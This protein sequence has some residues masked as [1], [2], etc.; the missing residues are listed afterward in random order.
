MGSEGL[1]YLDC[2]QGK[3]VIRRHSEVRRI[4]VPQNNTLRDMIGHFVDCIN[5]RSRSEPFPNLIDGT[6]GARVVTLVDAA[7][8]S[9][10]QGRR[11]TLRLPKVARQELASSSES[12]LELVE[13]Q[14]SNEPSEN[15]SID[16]PSASGG[17]FSIS[18][19]MEAALEGK[20]RGSRYRMEILLRLGVADAGPKDLATS[21]GLDISNLGK[22]LRDL[23][24][25]GLVMLKTPSDMRK[26]KIYGL[27]RKGYELFGRISGVPAVRNASDDFGAVES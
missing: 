23:A 3:A 14:G 22:Y 19:A 16:R 20:L 11:L 2:T 27:T 7:R 9:A 17:F 5:A 10:I 8:E 4:P 13:A 26:G 18:S 15:Y 1:A 24:Q 25:D 12:P 21:V 6:L